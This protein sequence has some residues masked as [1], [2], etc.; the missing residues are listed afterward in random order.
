MLTPDPPRRAERALAAA[1]ATSQAGAFDAA[2][3]LL[4]LAE[5]GR[6]ASFSK[7]APISDRR[8]ARVHDHRAA[9]LRPCR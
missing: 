1:A 9:T 4:S 2:R 5:R 6:S 8:R 7:P 3:D